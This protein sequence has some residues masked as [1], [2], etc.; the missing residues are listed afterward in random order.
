MMVHCCIDGFIVEMDED[1]F[2][3]YL[4]WYLEWKYANMDADDSD[5]E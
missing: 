3:D 4:H 2:N 1:E 5:K